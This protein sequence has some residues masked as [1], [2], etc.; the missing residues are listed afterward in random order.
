MLDEMLILLK[1]IDQL[2]ADDEKIRYFQ[3]AQSQIILLYDDDRKMW[4]RD[5]DPQLL[6]VIRMLSAGIIAS[7]LGIKDRSI[8]FEFLCGLIVLLDGN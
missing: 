3:M 5:R 2:L 6:E 4:S 8:I 7:R 1:L